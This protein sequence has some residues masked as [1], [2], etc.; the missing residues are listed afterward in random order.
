M[1]D[2]IVRAGGLGR[3][4]PATRLFT[5]CYERAKHQGADAVRMIPEA[6]WTVRPAPPD[7]DGEA[8]LLLRGAVL[9]RVRGQRVPDCSQQQKE[10]PSECTG[11]PALLSP[12][13]VAALAEPPSAPGR[14]LLRLLRADGLLTPLVLMVALALAAGG[15]VVEA[16]YQRAL[17]IFT[18]VYGADHFE[19]AVTLN[20]LA[21]L[22][23]ACG[24]LAEAE[25]AYQRAMALKE[26]LFGR[27]HLEV[28]FTANNLAMLYAVQGRYAEA[29]P[30]LRRAV[31]IFAATLAPQHPHVVTC[32]ENYAAVRREVRAT[33]V[34]TSRPG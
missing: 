1:T 8:R 15:I 30:L 24:R 20:N 11:G 4:R 22:Q 29:A 32:Q 31:R 33:R 10:M 23:H 5:A 13:L 14:T 7:A 6:Y 2:A 16:L 25:Q 12:E 18:R 21:A 9:V 19:V 26:Q 3:G 17:A 27:Q 34:A 28:A